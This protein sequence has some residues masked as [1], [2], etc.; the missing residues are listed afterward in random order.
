L[1]RLLGAL[2][3]IAECGLGD[4][5]LQPGVLLT[6]GEFRGSIVQLR[7]ALASELGALSGN[8][9]TLD[10]GL[11]A[12]WWHDLYGTPVDTRTPGRCH[13]RPERRHNK[14]PATWQGLRSSVEASS[15][16][17]HLTSQAERVRFA[18]LPRQ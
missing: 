14:V 12:V 13:N 9:S 4:K 8:P 5:Y 15:L 6:G 11:T 1:S 18:G 3:R 10:R 16:T 7:R 17:S 2:G